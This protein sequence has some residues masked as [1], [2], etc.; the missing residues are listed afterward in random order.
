[1]HPSVMEFLRKILKYSEI[2]GMEILEVGSQDV[3]GSPREVVKGLN[4]GKYVGVDFV[5]GAGVDLVLPV[6][7]L[8]ARFGQEAFDVVISTEMLEHAQDW[9]TAVDQMK[10]VLK[11]GGLLVVTTRGPGFPYHGYPHDYWRYRIE[12]FEQIFADMAIELLAGD[13]QYPGVFLKARKTVTTGHVDLASIEVD[14][15]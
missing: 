8:G 12:H 3:N 7:K 15:V 9:R 14:R 6:E 5:R 4:P 2:A 1:M 11:T 13:P 10:G